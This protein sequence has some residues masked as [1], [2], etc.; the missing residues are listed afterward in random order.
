VT[1]RLGISP[2]RAR[3]LVMIERRT[4]EAP[5]LGEAYREG[6]LSWVRALAVL[7]VVGEQ[8]A[9]EWVARAEEVPVRRLADE[10]EWALTVR[11]GLA[12]IAP[13]PAGASLAVPERQLCARPEWEWS[14]AEISFSAPVSVVS[15]LQSAVL[16]YAY[17]CDSLCG[18]LEKLLLHVKAEWESQPRHRDPVFARDGWRCAVPVCTSRRNLHDHHLVFRSRG[19]DKR[20]RESHHPLRVAPPPGHPRR[21][22]A[23]MG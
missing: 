15:L 2:R 6:R 5:A 20:A 22:R 1:E 14:D 13:P 18:G 12:D 10:V 16:A 17:P 3:A 19:G 4:W 7:P 8:T 11:D 9:A 21:T 23:G